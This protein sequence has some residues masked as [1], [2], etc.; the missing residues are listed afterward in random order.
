MSLELWVISIFHKAALQWDTSMQ[1][2]RHYYCQ[3]LLFKQR[4]DATLRLEASV[5]APSLRDMGP[6]GSGPGPGGLIPHT[7]NQIPIH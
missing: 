2:G 7:F 4:M 1:I 5:W 6:I 3:D